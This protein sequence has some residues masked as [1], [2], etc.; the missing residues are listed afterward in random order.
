MKREDQILID[1]LADFV[2][3]QSPGAL[4]EVSLDALYQTACKHNVTG[5]VAELLH[6]FLENAE[7]PAVRK[8]QESHMATVFRSVLLEEEVKLFSAR[9]EEEKIPYAFFKGYEL[10]ELYPVPELRTMGDVDVLV[11]D[12]DLARTAEVLCGLGYQKEEGG[13][14]VWAFKKDNFTYEVHRRLAFGSYWN[15]IFLCFH[16][17]KHLNSTGAGIRMVMD[18]TLFLKAYQDTLDRDYIREQLELLRM[19]R[20]VKTVL[21]ASGEWFGIPA[22]IDPA[23]VLF[24]PAES[25]LEDRISEEKAYGLFH[26]GAGAVSG[27][28]AGGLDKAVAARAAEPLED[29]GGVQG[30]RSE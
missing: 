4:P 10:K 28:P 27:A 17:A 24:D 7:E 26:S 21:Y 22:N 16:L 18:L 15:F 2:N 13:G 9:M 29:E 30:D 5:I 1:L 25:T 19:D 11:R 3:G 20:F 12:E 8:L 6:P 23:G 14:A